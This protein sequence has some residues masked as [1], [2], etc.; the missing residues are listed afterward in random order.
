MDE[1]NSVSRIFKINFTTVVLTLLILIVLAY[2]VSDRQT[3]VEVKPANAAVQQAIAGTEKSPGYETFL[4]LGLQYYLAREFEKS[5]VYS[6]KAL[7]YDPNGYKA[8]NNLCAAYCE[9]NFPDEAIKAG[10]QAL[11]LKP[12]FNLAKNNL[13]W[14]YQIKQKKG[15]K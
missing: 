5:I 4:E 11:S 15:L 12:D 8:Y 3:V 13:N 10:E 14:A 7:S 1:H 9:L 2:L 6:W